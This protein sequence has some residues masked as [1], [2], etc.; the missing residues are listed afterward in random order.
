MA[1]RTFCAVLGVL[2]A[3]S[4]PAAAQEPPPTKEQRARQ[5]LVLMRTADMGMQIIDQMIGAMKGAMPDAGEEFW[6]SFR[7]KAKNTDFVDMLVPVYAKNID[8]AD[9]DELIRF[10]S[11]PAGQRFLDKQPVIMQ[12]SMTI[13]QKWGEALATQAIQELQKKKTE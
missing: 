6:T 13:G 12:E 3:L 4:V 11:S 10:Y 9:L 7:Q 8:S 5:L 1:S 2:L